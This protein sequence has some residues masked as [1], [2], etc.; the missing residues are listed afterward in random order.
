MN[1]DIL[2]G[3][4]AAVYLRLV[5]PDADGDD[6]RRAIDRLNWLVRQGRLRPLRASKPRSYWRGELERFAREETEAFSTTTVDIPD[7]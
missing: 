6:R 3:L 1:N 4:E 7:P 5:E 2:T